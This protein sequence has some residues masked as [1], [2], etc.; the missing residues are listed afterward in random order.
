MNGKDKRRNKPI[1]CRLGFHGRSSLF[2]INAKLTED[3]DY[4]SKELFKGREL[5]LWLCPLCGECIHVKFCWKESYEKR[6]Q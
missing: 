5:K 3:R 4:F 1:L 2:E 6:G